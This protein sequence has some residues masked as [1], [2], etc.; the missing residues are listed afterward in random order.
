MAD[1]PMNQYNSKQIHVAGAKRGKN[2]R[3]SH[4]CFFFPDRWTIA[5]A[6]YFCLLLTCSH[7]TANH[8][9]TTSHFTSWNFEVGRLRSIFNVSFDWFCERLTTTVN[10]NYVLRPVCWEYS[11]KTGPFGE[12]QKMIYVICPFPLN[13][14]INLSALLE[15]N[16][17]SYRIAW[18]LWRGSPVN[19]LLHKQHSILKA[20]SLKV[21]I[22]ALLYF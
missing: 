15:S 19:M 18:L 11:P 16:S 9:S 20:S 14:C 22:N 4:D 21:S 13:S 3:A 1:N 10:Q 7:P 8:S 6:K 17:R 12:I 2:V 5:V